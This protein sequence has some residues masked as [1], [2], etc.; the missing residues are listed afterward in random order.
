M[1][2]SLIVAD[3]VFNDYS[4]EGVP[5]IRMIVFRGFPVMGM[6]RL[7]TRASDGK[8]NLHQGAVGVGLDIASGKSLRAVNLICRLTGTLIRVTALKNWKYLTGT[9]CS[10]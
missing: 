8:A 3:P 5:D 6:L 1:I 9:N 2:E 4:F 10:S 7:A